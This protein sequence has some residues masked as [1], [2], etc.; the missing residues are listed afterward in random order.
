MA[1]RKFL[2]NIILAVI[3]GVLF[4]GCALPPPTPSSAEELFNT[5]QEDLKKGRYEESKYRFEKVFVEYPNTEIAGNALFRMGYICA[6]QK[7]YKSARNYFSL[8]VEDYSD[9]KW[10]FDAQTWLN[11]LDDWARL[12]SELDDAKNQLG[13]AQRQRQTDTT[14]TKPENDTAGRIHELQEQITKLR[15]ENNRLRLLIET[16]DD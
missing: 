5:A 9:S 11:L 1:S 7:D 3:S 15:E 4:Y 8:L 2:G 6:I 13:I 10:K 14:G 16:L 12:K